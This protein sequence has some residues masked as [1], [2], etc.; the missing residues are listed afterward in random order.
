LKKNT[1]NNFVWA[2]LSK[3]SANEGCEKNEFGHP[4][5]RL[6]AHTKKASRFLNAKRHETVIYTLIPRYLKIKVRSIGK[7]RRHNEIIS[8]P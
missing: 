7:M 4:P 6:E 2:L 5:E 3:A 8:Q 1:P